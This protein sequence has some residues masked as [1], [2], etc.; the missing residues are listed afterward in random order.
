MDE[1]SLCKRRDI[2]PGGLR[3]WGGGECF[4]EVGRHD[5][6]GFCVHGFDLDFYGIPHFCSGI[7]EEFL[8]RF[9][10]VTT[11]A[12]GLEGGVEVVIVEGAFDGDHCSGGQFVAG[13]FGEGEEGPGGWL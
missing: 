9:E 8:G 11:L 13:F 12:V 6:L 3:I 2:F 5:G 7:L 4:F 10:P 1:V